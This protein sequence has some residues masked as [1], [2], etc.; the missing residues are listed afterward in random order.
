MGLAGNVNTP[1][2][3]LA[4]PVTAWQAGQDSEV[5]GTPSTQTSVETGFY[6]PNHCLMGGRTPLQCCCGAAWRFLSGQG[7]LVGEEDLTLPFH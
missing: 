6:S 2:E 3:V 1:H 5:L 4:R 7:W